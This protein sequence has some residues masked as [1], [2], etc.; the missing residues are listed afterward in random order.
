LAYGC[1]SLI[2]ALVLVFAVPATIISWALDQPT[3][4]VWW[5][6]GVSSSLTLVC[7]GYFFW[8]RSFKDSVPDFLHYVTREFFTRDGLSFAILPATHEGIC[9]LE[10]Y[11]QNQHDEACQARIALRPAQGFFLTRAPIAEIL[12]QVECP[13]AGF[14]VARVPLPLEEK[15][16]GQQHTFDV[17]TSVEWPHGP[18]NQVRHREGYRVPGNAKFGSRFQTGLSIAAALT[19]QVYLSKPASV[20]ILLPRNVPTELPAGLQPELSVIWQLGDE[21]PGEAPV[22]RE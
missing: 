14:G 19:G 5:T 4:A 7:G 2:S 13:P 3:P 6:R 20:K 21:I 22:R 8:L 1:L 18:G 15:F 12:L 11:W 10:I 16:Q 17:G 9:F